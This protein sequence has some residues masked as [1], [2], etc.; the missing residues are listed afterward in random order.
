MAARSLA[1]GLTNGGSLEEGKLL[2]Q[3]ADQ[4][5]GVFLWA[6][7]V[8]GGATVRGGPARHIAACGTERVVRHKHTR[9]ALRQRETNQP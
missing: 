1:P 2:D 8:W 4:L 6:G 7:A 9:S 5:R 3:A